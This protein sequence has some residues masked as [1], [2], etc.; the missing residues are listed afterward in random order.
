MDTYLCTTYSILFLTAVLLTSNTDTKYCFFMSCFFVFVLCYCFWRVISFFFLLYFFMPIKKT[1][2][3]SHFPKFGINKVHF[4]HKIIKAKKK[5]KNPTLR[6]KHYSE[7]VPV[8]FCFLTLILNM[9]SF[10]FNLIQKK[11]PGLTLKTPEWLI[12]SEN[13]I[14]PQSDPVS[15]KLLPVNRNALY[16][17]HAGMHH[18]TQT[19]T[20]HSLR[21]TT[22]AA[23]S[24]A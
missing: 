2:K 1:Q 12:R 11:P 19:V 14:R 15:Y 22:N 4:I 6:C 23:H 20:E 8:G 16:A 18:S 3:N 10:A 9:T 5:E 17:L 13:M 24:P 21:Q 7:N